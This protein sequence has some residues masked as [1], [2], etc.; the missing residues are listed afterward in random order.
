MRVQEASLVDRIK[1]VTR[2]DR[3][4]GL[5]ENYSSEGVTRCDII[6]S[7]IHDSTIIKSLSDSGRLMGVAILEMVE[8]NRTASIHFAMFESFNI[9]RCFSMMLDLVGDRYDLIYSYIKE[10]RSDIASILKFLDFN[11]EQPDQGWIYGWLKKE[12]ESTE[13]CAVSSCNS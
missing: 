4:F 10:N 6:D 9:K 5:M 8:D 2:I 7:F 1:I 12:T 3:Q 11:L 13:A